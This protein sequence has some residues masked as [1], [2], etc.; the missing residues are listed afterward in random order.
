MND[1][2]NKKKKYANI[3][4]RLS[5]INNKIS[6]L[7]QDVEELEKAM[8]KVILLNDKIYN[9]D[10]INSIKKTLTNST[11]VISNNRYSTLKKSY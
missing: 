8:S 5:L 7:S 11:T 1:D 3:S 2:E 10:A 6:N 4:Y 9:G